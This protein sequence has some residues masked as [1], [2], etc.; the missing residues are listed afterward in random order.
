MKLFDQP[1]RPSPDFTSPSRRRRHVKAPSSP[2]R[3]LTGASPPLTRSQRMNAAD[4]SATVAT[5]IR[6]LKL[7]DGESP[8]VIIVDT[9]AGQAESPKVMVVDT[10]LSGSGSGRQNLTKEYIKNQDAHTSQL[11]GSKV[12]SDHTNPSVQVP[13]TTRQ[14]IRDA[15]VV[16]ASM[17]SEE[18]KRQAQEDPSTEKSPSRKSMTP[19]VS[20]LS[21]SSVLSGI[22]TCSHK[23]EFSHFGSEGSAADD[24]PK[25]VYMETEICSPRIVDCKDDTLVAEDNCPQ[26]KIISEMNDCDVNTSPVILQDIIEK[27]IDDV[28][29]GCQESPKDLP[30]DRMCQ[31]EDETEDSVPEDIT[32]RSEETTTQRQPDDKVLELQNGRGSMHKS[33][34]VDSGK[35]CS[36]E[37]LCEVDG[38]KDR[39]ME[40]KLCAD[41]QVSMDAGLEDGCAEV[42]GQEKDANDES[43]FTILEGVNVEKEIVSAVE[44]H[45]TDEEIMDTDETKRNQCDFKKDTTMIDNDKTIIAMDDT[46]VRNIESQSDADKLQKT[47]P[48]EKN[49]DSTSSASKP[50]SVFKVPKCI[51]PTI[52]D[53]DMQTIINAALKSDMKKSL[54]SRSQ[55]LPLQDPSNAKKN[56]SIVKANIQLFNSF[57]SSQQDVSMVQRG[58]QGR[59]RIRRESQRETRSQTKPLTPLTKSRSVD[60]FISEVQAETKMSGRHKDLNDSFLMAVEGRVSKKKT[61]STS[62]SMENISTPTKDLNASYDKAIEAGSRHTIRGAQSMEN[63]STPTSK[64]LSPS[65]RPVRN[66]KSMQNVSTPKNMGDITSPSSI[67]RRRPVSQSQKT[68]FIESESYMRLKK[69]KAFDVEDEEVVPSVKPLGDNNSPRLRRN[70]RPPPLDPRLATPLTPCNLPQRSRG[71]TPRGRRA[72]AVHNLKSPVKPVKRLGKSPSPGRGIYKLTPDGENRT[73]KRYPRSPKNPLNASSPKGR[74]PRRS[75]VPVHVQDEWEL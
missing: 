6:Q 40:G 74:R 25:T 43:T 29:D 50:C 10:S 13:D 16:F 53:E 32:D 37:D 35:G 44:R 47:K 71:H 59:T 60:S 68:A 9:H 5:P 28:S 14:K 65:K 38:G 70:R 39:E 46:T 69:Q 15:Q 17:A 30:G 23:S 42:E 54:R 36:M 41:R 52:S 66:A 26:D 48:L 57:C 19:S 67:R 12:G 18:S 63:I 31:G 24:K 11:I 34:S 20:Q 64:T 27:K 58:D 61:L 33:D 56:A 75:A 1:A 51:D 8:K 73:P 2:A 62:A 3:L 55:T 72:A 22:S 21:L 4:C 45:S 7:S 49:E